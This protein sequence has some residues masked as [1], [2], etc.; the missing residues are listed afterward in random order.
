[1]TE[2]PDAY[3]VTLRRSLS[4]LKCEGP[5][6]QRDSQDYCEAVAGDEIDTRQSV[7]GI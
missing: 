4:P 2:V 6:K 1:M 7:T 5:H 3:S